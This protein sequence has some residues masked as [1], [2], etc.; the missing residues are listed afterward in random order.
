MLHKIFSHKKKIPLPTDQKKSHK[1]TGN[2]NI[3][4]V[5]PNQGL[6]MQYMDHYADAVDPL[7]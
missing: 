1:V 6:Y 5:R 4:F 7:L 2:D 3:F